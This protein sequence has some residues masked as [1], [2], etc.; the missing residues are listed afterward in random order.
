MYNLVTTYI[1]DTEGFQTI[2]VLLQNCYCLSLMNN[3]VL[4]FQENEHI[5]SAIVVI[6]PLGTKQGKTK[7]VTATPAIIEIADNPATSTV[8]SEELT[9]KSSPKTVAKN[10]SKQNG[11]LKH[12]DLLIS[13]S[14][15]CNAENGIGQTAPRQHSLP[16]RH[17]QCTTTL[18][19]VKTSPVK[20]LIS[21]KGKVVPVI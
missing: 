6:S 21:V 9:S 7:S 2:L 4:L 16:I 18:K 13:G 14:E 19:L 1:T 3:Q 11:R 20:S 5:N 15:A 10:T 12:F 8:T 17:P